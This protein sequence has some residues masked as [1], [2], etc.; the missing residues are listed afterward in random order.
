MNKVRAVAAL[1]AILAIII[2]LAAPIR[3]LL[4][5]PTEDY[6]SNF[7]IYMAWFNWATLLWFVSAPIWMVPEM[8]RRK[9]E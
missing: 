9:R 5:G 1:A 7:E 4:G 6:Q 2:C 8:F 3:V